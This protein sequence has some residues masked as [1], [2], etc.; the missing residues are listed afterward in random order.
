[1]SDDPT[2]IQELVQEEIN[3][4]ETLEAVLT[5]AVKN[6]YEN[7]LLM[8][9]E[10]AEKMFAKEEPDMWET[11]IYREEDLIQSMM[12]DIKYETGYSAIV[13]SH[14]FAQAIWGTYKYMAY[15]AGYNEWA[16]ATEPEDED[17][18]YDDVQHLRMPQWQ[19]H[20]QQMVVADDT[21]AYLKE[22]AL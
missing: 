11:Y 4:L 7:S 18:D 1:M 2:V 19:Y 20:L 5:K 3:F 16:D 13:F 14:E 17:A 12:Q 10:E 9:R 22:H 6:G 15:Y 21:L 8:N